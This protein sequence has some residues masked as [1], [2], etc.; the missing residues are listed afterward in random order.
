MGAL[1]ADPSAFV[2]E[3]G[4]AFSI[5]LMVRGAK[6][7]G[8]I[9]KIEGG[10][11]AFPGVRNA[12]LN[13]S[14]GRLAVDWE[15]SR[16]R[17]RD[18]VERLTEL[19]Y[20]AA[21][22][23]P[24]A[25]AS[26]S[27]QS[28]EGKTLLRAM[29]VAAFAMANVMLLSVSVWSGG[30]EMDA[31]TRALMHWLSALIALPAIAYSA[32]P[33]FRSALGALKA[34]Q[35]N[36][37]VP[38]SL[39]VL[40]ASGLS[41]VETL[42]GGET[43]F[44]AAVMLLFFLLIG[45]FLDS[46]LRARAG[47]AARQLAAM[48]AATANRIG[49]DGALKTI[50]A[51]E[52]EAGDRLVIAAGERVPVDAEV[53]AG[54]S[55]V[56]GALVTGE[57]DPV[58]TAP[59]AAIYSGMVNLTAPLTVRA[60]A[61]REDSLLAEIAR[62]VEAGQQNRSR[63][64]RLADRAARLYVPVVHTLAALT[65]LG[66]LA[67]TGDFRPAIINAIAVLIIT[68]PCALGLAVPA[69]QV[70]ASGRLFREGVLVKSGDTLERL[71]EAD[72]AV[73]DKTGTL[74]FGEPKLI[75][76][77]AIP[78]GVLDLAA[79]LC[80]ASRHPLSCAVADHAGPGPTADYVEETSGAGMSAVIDNETIR[81][82]SARWLGIKDA[83]GDATEAW[84][85]AGQGDPVR[86]VFEDRIRPGAAEAIAALTRRGLP[87][88]LLSGD[89]NAAVEAVAAQL[90]VAVWRGELKPQDKIA[91]LEALAGEG[92]RVLMVGDG[93]NDAPA[94]AAAHVSASPARAADISQAASDFVLQND[95]LAGLPLAL[96]VARSSRRRIVENFSFAA[97][98]NMCAVPL[99][100][101]GFVT[102]LI[103]AIA[104]SGS[105]IIVTLNALRLS[106]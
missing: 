99:A 5:D 48:Q 78:A 43:Y 9:A 6:C 55:E 35:V 29:A 3:K 34:R 11:R 24:D 101:F 87:V 72:Y 97:L 82:G 106:K 19:G 10:M 26:A 102:P 41:V 86:F 52:V 96:D 13:L 88:E 104:M 68:C 66:W 44:D 51:S 74:T 90:G 33:F 61:R 45:R 100:V 67:F 36:M 53:E 92:R 91:R 54:A 93:L 62:L 95:R 65:V 103:A 1:T 73:F 69:V 14:T 71:S 50:R 75:N 37:D 15:G 18:F 22:F 77:D 59:G 81:F 21:P 12:R 28:A 85:Q 83:P 63:Y 57:T 23:D 56:D 20:T 4:E 70:V 40:L 17:A 84:L 49:P 2:R 30:G 105:S 47:Q 7:G 39:A 58:R 89:R 98:Y 60:L 32:R 80:R 31:A 16:D 94:L 64:V 38:I 8:C 42:R 25:S 79:R 76:A 27:A 46:R